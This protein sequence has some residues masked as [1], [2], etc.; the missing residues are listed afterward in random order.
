MGIHAL[1]A[2]V[3]VCVTAVPLA[4]SIG[5]SAKTGRNI[6]RPFRIRMTQPPQQESRYV[7]AAGLARPHIPSYGRTSARRCCSPTARQ[8]VSPF[9]RRESGRP[10][11]AHA[12]SAPAPPLVTTVGTREEP[13]QPRPAA[14]T[15][16]R[17]RR[18]ARQH[19]PLAR[20]GSP[21]DRGRSRRFA[22]IRLVQRLRATQRRS[23][24]R[25]TTLAAVAMFAPEPSPDQERRGERRSAVLYRSVVRA[26]RFSFGASSRSPA[27]AIA[28][29]PRRNHQT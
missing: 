29:R 21:R 4:H 14:R 11:P 7:S 12:I 1:D 6:H 24:S 23:T 19:A 2:R 9:A 3:N 13:C 17:L 10:A 8:E 27:A 25:D 26:R 5:E 20:N 22:T 18:C 16:R 15:V 28:S